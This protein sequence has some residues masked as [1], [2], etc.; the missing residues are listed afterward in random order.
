MLTED[1]KRRI[2]PLALSLTGFFFALPV[3]ALIKAEDHLNSLHLGYDNLAS[4]RISY[5]RFTLG[6][7]N[8]FVI[9]GLMIM[10]VLNAVHGM[11]YLHSRQE[12]DFYGSVPVLRTSKFAAAYIKS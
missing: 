12:A 8:G 4:L 11:K 7:S 2:W 5:A 10:A 6:G 1:L 3:L 9:A